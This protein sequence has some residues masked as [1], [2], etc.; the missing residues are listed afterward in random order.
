MEAPVSFQKDL[1]YI[2]K[3]LC[4]QPDWRLDD[5]DGVTSG[6]ADYL[7]VAI[8]NTRSL[9]LEVA[10]DLGFWLRRSNQEADITEVTDIF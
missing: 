7:S 3:L 10:V 8:N 5:K 1:A 4:E 9:A 2:L 6:Q